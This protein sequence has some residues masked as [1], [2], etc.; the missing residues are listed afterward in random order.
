MSPFQDAKLW[1][2]DVTGLAKDA[3]H[4]YVGLTVF[5][6]AAILLRR[7]LRDWRPLAAVVVAA[8]AGEV[9]DIVDTGL[10][11]QRLRLDLGWHDIWNTL[12]WPAVLFAAFR[13]TRLLRA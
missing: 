7:P 4:V 13:W 12:F 11:G 10:A 5:L 6:L 9:W 1:L 8:L 2:G 3:M